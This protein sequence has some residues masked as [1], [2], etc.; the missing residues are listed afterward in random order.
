MHFFQLT[1][2]ASC[3]CKSRLEISLVCELCQFALTVLT[4]WSERSQGRGQV[5]GAAWSWN[6]KGC[7]TIS[8]WSQRVYKH[9][10]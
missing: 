8:T 2:P 1:V 7:C 9:I 10:V 4:G 5:C 6:G 3:S